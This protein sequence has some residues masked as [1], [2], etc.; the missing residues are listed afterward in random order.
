MQQSLNLNREIIKL[1]F[2]VIC[3]WNIMNKIWS[4][5]NYFSDLYDI[6]C[7]VNKIQHKIKTE[8]YPIIGLC[9]DVTVVFMQQDFSRFPEAFLQNCTRKLSFLGGV[10]HWLHTSCNG[11]IYTRCITVCSLKLNLFILAW[12]WSTFSQ[13][14]QIIL[15]S[16]FWNQHY[17]CHLRNHSCDLKLKL[18]LL[19]NTPNYAS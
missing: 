9:W 13:L 6:I 14:I 8:F 11:K 5:T 18:Q 17:W 2:D 12:L 15:E 1:L 7:M 4:V 16:A 3:K 10:V 19:T